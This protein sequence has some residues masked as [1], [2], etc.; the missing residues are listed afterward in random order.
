M[1][2]VGALVGGAVG[3][4]F[5][6]FVGA[7]AGAALFGFAGEI[8][9]SLIQLPE[10]PAAIKNGG[11]TYKADFRTNDAQIGDVRQEAFGLTTVWPQNA[12][13]PWSVYDGK[14][15]IRHA[16]LHVT[17]GEFQ[18]DAIRL[19]NTAM[20]SLSGSQADVLLP[21][22]RNALFHSNVY[23]NP[24]AKD[25]DLLGGALSEIAATL[26]L[27][28]S[29]GRITFIDSDPALYAIPVGVTVT[30]SG[31]AS[32]NGSY[33]VTNIGIEGRPGAWRESWIDAAASFVTESAPAATISFSQ[34]NTDAQTVK[35]EQV[36]FVFSAALSQVLG[37]EDPDD[38]LVDF[39]VGDLVGAYDGVVT[40]ANREWTVVDTLGGRGLVLAGDTVHDE[41]VTCRLILKR[42][43]VGGYVSCPSGATVDQIAL[44]FFWRA[45]YHA[46][47][48]TIGNRSVLFEIRWRPVDDVG[49]PTGDWT[50]QL[51]TIVGAT[52]S[53][54][55]ETKYVT[56]DPPCRA[57]VDVCRVTQET[58]NSQVQD[59]ATLG[60]LL[61]FIVDKPG[62]DPAVDAECT[63]LAVQ[64]RS[65]GQ[66]ARLAENSVNVDG[67]RWLSIWN[68]TSWSDPQPTR[69]IAWAA[70]QWLV[71]MSRGRIAHADLDAD[72]FLACDTAWETSGDTFDGVFDQK[73]GFL[74]G[75]N[76]ILRCGRAQL[77]RD[78]QAG[79]YS[80]Y[81]DVP[82][83]PVLLLA[84]GINCDLGEESIETPSS[85]SV[86]GLSVTWFDPLLRTSR[87]GPVVGL[88]TDPEEIK[89]LGLSSWR[90]AF[91]M[92]TYEFLKGK[93]RVHSIS[94]DTEMEGTQ[95]SIGD[96]VL[97]SSQVKMFGQAAAVTFIDGL[98]LTVWPPL[99]WTTGAQ[100]YVYLSGRDG[101]PG[102]RINCTRGSSDD[103][104]VLASAIDVVVRE[105]DDTAPMAIAFGHDGT[106]L[107][108]ADGPLVVLVASGESRSITTPDGT[109]VQ[110]MGASLS[111]L[112]DDDRIHADPGEAPPDTAGGVGTAPILSI[113]GLALTVDGADV[114]LVW[115]AVVVSGGTPIYEAA[116]RYAGALDWTV[117][118][119]GTSTAA[120]FTAPL[121]GVVQVRVRGLVAERLIREQIE[122]AVI[123]TGF[124][125]LTA[126]SNPA[127]V[128]GSGSSFLPITS[129]AS[130]LTITGGSPPYLISTE[131]V[132]GDTALVVGG[133]SVDVRYRATLDP[134]ESQSGVYRRRVED[135]LGA[136]VY[137]NPISYTLTRTGSSGG[138]AIP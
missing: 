39:R 103:E 56:I 45:L 38:S 138:G 99:T 130:S 43:R 63:R 69:S 22:V 19:G 13:Q 30:I 131:H 106:E 6:G 4:L 117:I 107:V 115:D 137:S 18:I 23:T 110:A 55:R 32:N 133:F 84:D 37:P 14:N 44:H 83:A 113:T 59:A 125:V 121:T 2:I 52:A 21:G 1:N 79:L 75:V 58:D 16:L 127:V 35:S 87:P 65:S 91:E 81:R 82:T 92:V 15:E 54:W 62:D 72:L 50:S 95:L 94:A 25:L 47:G 77:I 96:R 104:L 76:T 80:I 93:L 51:V 128:Y 3:F 97:L 48:D 89:M 105:A 73:P 31:T 78:Y 41:T 86:T 100:H 29:G 40:N 112:V 120:A 9:G 135:S 57:E 42:R 28:F 17:V 111:L 132:S 64:V 5:G 119:R 129:S 88:D 49:T 33:L 74:E 46:A 68:G 122:E 118:Q 124:G 98:T 116:W 61:G 90:K 126:V 70:A 12:S 20:G 53:A 27:E 66:L 136:I 134:G 101:A 10:A 60:G 7:A 108:P 123:D 24:D 67:Q 26:P 8:I 36:E 114:A 71:G 34:D 102:A 85:D 109:E 11:K